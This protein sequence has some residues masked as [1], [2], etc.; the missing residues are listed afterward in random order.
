MADILKIVNYDEKDEK[1]NVNDSLRETDETKENKRDDSYYTNL[2]KPPSESPM[3]NTH[4]SIN[5]D[6][7]ESSLKVDSNDKQDKENYSQ[8]KY[9]Q[10]LCHRKNK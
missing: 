4:Y 5:T 8:D 1:E 6:E 2:N 9:P 10:V 3:E 7:V